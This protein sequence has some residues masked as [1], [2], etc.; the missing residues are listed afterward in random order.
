M[1]IESFY[2][3]IG[4]VYAL[5]KYIPL[6][7][8]LTKPLKIKTVPHNYF[9]INILI[10]IVLDTIALFFH[11]IKAEEIYVYVL[12]PF[13]PIN[14]VLF[15]GLFL[16]HYISQ[17]YQKYFRMAIPIL[18]AIVASVYFFSERTWSSIGSLFQSTVMI[19][20]LLVALRFLVLGT[21]TQVNKKSTIL[22]TLGLLF[23]F[24]ASVIIN[25]Y[26]GEMMR[27]D[28]KLAHLFYGIKNIFWILSNILTIYAISI[29]TPIS[30]P[31]P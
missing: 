2:D 18:I 24:S 22:I 29:L 25:L 23:A 26:Y 16:T 21:K 7:L 4:W 10:S 5:G 12:L 3:I 20:L 14:N 6:L 15:L 9:F 31:K 1:N 8:F 13:Y 19:T 17:P 30:T 11:E 28:E 27:T